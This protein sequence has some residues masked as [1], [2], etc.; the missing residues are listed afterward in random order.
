MVFPENKELVAVNVS[1]GILQTRRSFYFVF[2]TLRAL[3]KGRYP[4]GG[5]KNPDGKIVVYFSFFAPRNLSTPKIIE[6]THKKG[7]PSNG[8]VVYST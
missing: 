1:A 5:A 6:R 3:S 2:P 4:Q 8:V 7:P